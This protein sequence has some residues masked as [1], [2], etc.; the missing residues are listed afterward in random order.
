M[1]RSNTIARNGNKSPVYGYNLFRMNDIIDEATEGSVTNVSEVATSGAIILMTSEWNCNLDESI[2]KCNP[3]WKF[4]RIDNEADSISYGYN[5]R[6]VS[7]DV[8]ADYRLLRKLIGIRVILITDGTAGKFDLP[9]LT[10]TFGAGLAYLSVAKIIT[11]L[12]LGMYK[13]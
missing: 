9:T 11:D 3:K 2:S 6:S 10:I 8:T 4:K 12:V 5:F 13:F 7:Y 1:T